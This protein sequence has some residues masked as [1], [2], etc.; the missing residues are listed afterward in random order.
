[1]CFCLGTSVCPSVRLT[2]R[3]WYY[4]KTTLAKIRKSS[5][6]SSFLPS[7]IYPEIRLGSPR[8][9]TF[10][11]RGSRKVTICG[12]E[13]A[14]SPKWYKIGLRLLLIGSHV[15]FAWYRHQWPWMIFNGRYNA[16][17]TS[18]HYTCVWRANP[19][20]QSWMKIRQYYQRQKVAQGFQFM[21]IK[22]CVDILRGSLDRGVK[23]QWVVK[24][25]D[26]QVCESLQL[27]NL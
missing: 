25:G 17:R 7:K 18:L 20:V 11:E 8:A 16:I 22:V 23:R 26:F 4:L 6:D 5:S 27:R 3:V 14:M 12:V 15:F 10:N 2:A 21:A 9:K 1:M 24:R 13:V 19:T